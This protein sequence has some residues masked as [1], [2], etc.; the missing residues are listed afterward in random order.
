MS[1]FKKVSGRIEFAPEV[2][3]NISGHVGQLTAAFDVDPSAKVTVGTTPPPFV[4]TLT[5]SERATEDPRLRFE[6]FLRTLIEKL[7]ELRAAHAATGGSATGGAAAAIPGIVAAGAGALGGPPLAAA[8]AAAGGVALIVQ[9]LQD[10]KTKNPEAEY[11]E[12][13]ALAARR[14]RALALTKAGSF[15]DPLAFSYWKGRLKQWRAE[16]INKFSANEL[17]AKDWEELLK[18]LDT[19]RELKAKEGTTAPETD[20]PFE[21]TQLS[22]WLDQAVSQRI[23]FTVQGWMR[24]RFSE[25]G[26]E[27]RLDVLGPDGSH[28]AVHYLNGD[29]LEEW[30]AE[31]I[32][33]LAKISEPGDLPRALIDQNQHADQK[34]RARVV[35]GRLWRS[36]GK[37][38]GVRQLAIYVPPRFAATLDPCC[39]DDEFFNVDDEC[40]SGD[41][42][43]RKPLISTPSPIAFSECDEAGYF[44]FTYSEPPNGLV[45]KNIL[46]EVSGLSVSLTTKLVPIKTST[47]DALRFPSPLLLPF[48]SDDLDDNFAQVQEID[49]LGDEA[50]RNSCRGMHLD[51]ANQS[52]EEFDFNL[53]VR[54][55]DPL[56]TRTYIGED[57]TSI[58]ANAYFRQRVGRDA[59]L[60]WDGAPVLAQAQTIAHGRILT[61]K[62]SWRAD[63]YSLGDLLYSLP[64]APLQKKNIAVIDWGRSETNRL[65]SE[66]VNYEALN[67]TLSRDR[68]ISEIVN[69]TL[70]ESSRG[71]S[72]SESRAG[73]S[74]SGLL[75][76]VFGG[77]SGGSSSAWSSSSQ[78]STRNLTSN[79]LNALRDRT[80]QAANSFRSQRV[81]TV[82]QV[83]QSERVTASSET[84]AN[85]NACH[86]VT[87]QYYEVLRHF[88]IDHD[89]A[90]VRECLFIPL[91]IDPFDQE[92]ALR[93]RTALEPYISG[94][95]LLK[96]FDSLSRQKSNAPY[97][98]SRYADEEIGELSGDAVFSF[99]LPLPSS[100]LK[101][102]AYATATGYEILDQFPTEMAAVA[103]QPDPAARARMFQESV[104]PL[105]AKAIA[106]YIVITI[107]DSAGQSLGVPFSCSIAGTYSESGELRLLVKTK[108]DIN[109]CHVTRAAINSLLI[110]AK[111]LP[112]SWSMSLRSGWFGY[113]TADFRHALADVRYEAPGPLWQTVRNVTSIP[114]STPLRVEEVRNP[115]TEDIFLASLL[116][117]HLNANIEF[118]HKAIWWNM[119]PDRRY[120][121]LDGF[122]APNSGGRS[123]ASVV[124]NRVVGIVGNSLVMAVA[125]GTRLDHFNETRLE[126]DKESSTSG[127]NEHEIL[128]AYRP[129]IPSPATRI[130]VPTR[131]VFAESVL[132]GCNGCEKIDE[133]RNW[134]YWE[135]PLPDEPTQIDP[136]S[137]ASRGSAVPFI[138]PPLASPAV[139]QQQPLT[140]PDPAVSLAKIAEILGKGDSFR[141][142]AGLKGTQQS[143]RDA[144]EQS[145]ETTQHAYEIASKTLIE[146]AKTV[147][148]A[149]TSG[150]TSPGDA[151]NIKSSIG[152]DAKAGR[153]TKEQAQSAISKVNDA[154]AETVGKKEPVGLLDHPEVSSAI[155]AASDRGSPISLD[156]GGE[157]VEVGAS[158]TSRRVQGETRGSRLPWPLRLLFPSAE[159]SPIRNPSANLITSSEEELFRKMWDSLGNARTPRD[160]FSTKF[161]DQQEGVGTN[162]PK[163]F[164]MCATNLSIALQDAGLGV[165]FSDWKKGIVLDLR[166]RRLI[167]SAEQLGLMLESRIGPPIEITDRAE[168]KNYLNSPLLIG[169]QG[170]ICLDNFWAR[171]GEINIKTGDHIDL[172]NGTRIAHFYSNSIDSDKVRFWSIAMIAKYLNR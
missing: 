128:S 106:T 120:A 64:L 69:S 91:P 139:S 165:L 94:D 110:Q 16:G 19:F 80:N 39:M 113:A 13:V 40:C 31:T 137:T 33:P 101:A 17:P 167:A 131:G 121:L 83:N 28:L 169:R 54:T 118:Y 100:L 109:G 7:G 148:S 72:D 74:S 150:L 77:S 104:V 151:S 89:L 5:F 111:S 116:L 85:R 25:F 46:I 67:N 163:S 153:I 81:T 68:D 88:R 11:P 44:E 135:H 132:G 152:K 75:G 18:F 59:K 14:L 159:A 143:A 108:A 87:I 15:T 102:A 158:T 95:R 78:D 3:K 70:T 168:I 22:G 144:L 133:T 122:L 123:V 63:G 147:L 2:W 8:A 73:S 84:V 20:V 99:E 76:A 154:L 38:V 170:I 43:A 134:R 90:A 42:R 56:V 126:N 32:S 55:S 29:E 171:E 103:A 138:Q 136:L 50:E 47:G 12:Q 98:A 71:R 35:R 65:D 23:V 112:P 97:P 166:G 82:Q 160:V 60:L 52:L 30:F 86:A 119:D 96:A 41:E 114:I 1:I 115:K 62:Q 92:K 79:F 105:V 37:P 162:R 130:S 9:L 172:W 4:V 21:L 27:A 157:R 124:E 49:W 164:N 117:D 26:E 58:S 161:V 51:E 155:G 125:P 66:Q 34:D 107:V 141:D 149:Y 61:V 53:F 127:D 140:P 48:N 93:W 45:A 6:R 36:D 24:N 142:M 145:F 129:S 10:L 57:E 146:G 156:R